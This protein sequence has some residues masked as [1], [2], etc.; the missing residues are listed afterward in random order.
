VG[1]AQCNCTLL[2]V[3]VFELVTER[4]AELQV[5][6]EVLREPGHR[7]AAG[8]GRATCR[9]RPRSTAAAEREILCERFA[10][11]VRDRE[12]IVPASLA[13][14]EQITGSPVKI[15]ELQARDLDRP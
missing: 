3:C 14:H 4:S 10:D 8:H 1:R 6:V 11:I 9:R 12:P 7:A 5:V 2:A 15:V 13:A